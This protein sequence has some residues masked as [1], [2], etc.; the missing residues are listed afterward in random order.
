M[1]AAAASA[2]G[3]I[4]PAH[5]CLSRDRLIARNGGKNRLDVVLKR[6]VQRL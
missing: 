5:P 1:H 6:T 2:H 4:K 3:A